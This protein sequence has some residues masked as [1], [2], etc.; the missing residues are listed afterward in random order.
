MSRTR[1]FLGIALCALGLVFLF[2]VFRPGGAPVAESRT[3]ASSAEC[4]ACHAEVYAEWETSQ[5]AQSWTNPAVRMLSNDFANQDCIDCHAPR[6]VFHTGIGERVLPR[7]TR[8]EEGVDCIACHLLPDGRMA[9]TKTIDS[10][11][12][13]PVAT[14]DLQRPEFCAGCHNQHKTVDQWRESDW[15]ARGEDCSSCHMPF[16][17][18]DPNR[19]RAHVFPGGHDLVT[20]QRAVELRGRRV[21]DRWV[22]EVENVG[23]GHSYPTDERSRSSDLFW[24]PRGE[25]KWRHLYRIRDPY[26]TETDLASTLLHA[27]TTLTQE[28][29]GPDADGPIE[30]A[31]FYMRQPYWKDPADPD[32]LTADLSALVH[33]IELVP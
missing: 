20:V 17:D 13:R 27:N 32:P 9:G 19:G 1:I 29:T 8:R 10:A 6:P 28:I 16:R 7:I 5:H 26:R 30:V 21:D 2:E 15:P 4:R 3:F 24:R 25:E 11:P 23:A 31:L 33:A 14:L 12:C 22:I 18:A